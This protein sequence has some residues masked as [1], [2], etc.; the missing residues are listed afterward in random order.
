MVSDWTSGRRRPWAR[1]FEETAPEDLFAAAAELPSY[2]ELKILKGETSTPYVL[3]EYAVQID[4]HVRIYLS[5]GSS[6]S[7]SAGCW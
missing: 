2:L 5:F 3:M 1:D 7:D 6:R 4:R